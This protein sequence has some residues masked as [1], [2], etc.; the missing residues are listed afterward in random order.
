[1]SS[2]QALSFLSAA[3][4]DYIAE[5]YTKYVAN[6]ASVDESWA[7]LFGELG[8]DAKLLA[9]ELKGASWTPAPEK[10]SAVLSTPANADGA[11]PAKKDAKKAAPAAA[12]ARQAISD[13]VHALMLIRAYRNRGHLLA[14][15]DPLG[16]SEK[17][18][19]PDLD[20]KTYGFNDADMDREIYMDGAFG[21]EQ[22]T[23]REIV[24]VMRDTYCGSIGVEYMHI[25][26]P[27]QREWLQDR[28]ETSLNVT[29]FSGDE[30]KHILERLTASEG[31]EKFLDVKYTGTKRFGLEG[32]EAAIPAIEEII[33][34]GAELGIREVVLGMAHRGR[35]NVLTNV[36]NKSFT[37]MFSEFQGTPAKPDQVQGS[38]DV[39]YH[40]GTS[41]DRDFRGH[42]VHLS[43]TANPSHLEFVDPVVVGKTRAKQSIRKDEDRTEVMA[44]L[45]HGDAALA[46]QGIVPETLM[47]S[48]LGGYRVGGTM[49][50][51]INNQIGFTTAPHF[52]RSGPYCTDVAKMSQSPIFHVNGDDV[53]AVLHVARM[54]IEFRQTFHKDVFVDV[55]CY[56]RHG[57]N[58]GDEPA[59]T[60]PEMYKVIRGKKSTRTLYAEK[61]VGEGALTQE[62]ADKIYEDW[63]AYLEKEFQAATSYKPNRADMLE[64]TWSGLKVAYGEERSGET[65]ITDPLAKKIGKALTTVPEDFDLN[66]KIARQLEAKKEM[67]KSGEGFDWATAEALAFGSLVAEGQPVRLSG[68]DCGRGTFSQR[69]AVLVDQTNEDRY[70]P[71]NNIDAK[72][73]KFGVHD[74]PLSEAAVLGFEYGYSM[75]APRSLVLWEGQFGDFVNGAQVI[76]DQ[77]IASAETKWLRMSGL[78]ML[79]PHGFEGQGPEHSSGRLERFLQLSAEDNW[80]VL[81]CTTPANY[82]HALRRQMHR[83]FRKPLI[84]MTPKSL[85]R[86]KRCVS[87]LSDFIGKTRFSRVIGET[88]KIATGKDVKRVVICSGKVDYDLLD[89]R[90]KHGLKNVAVV[91][92][93]QLYPFP[94]KP[95]ADELK[96]YP[97]AEIIWCQEEPQNQGGWTFVDRRIESVLTGIKHKAGRPVYVGR[98]EAA[99]PATGSHKD[100][101]K[102]QEN[103]VTL[104]LGL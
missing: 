59:F 13:A 50:V 97:N 37:A 31:F 68:Q 7:E 81:N 69:H 33:A 32:G 12:D 8:E 103:I 75:A 5:L 34:R 14:H 21:F 67:F 23:L 93:E 49:H 22:T 56:R 83:D 58:E 9:Q 60:Q 36:M 85:L 65:A 95:L 57:H 42:T 6:P 71:L 4:P 16:L 53:E 77:F 52:S 51:V 104:A 61:L 82:F 94:E 91:R 19:H 47:M 79:L 40:L 24:Q 88:E 45:L 99:A 64:G 87:S 72:Q 101:V 20:P 3:D 28:F 89:A 48:D 35:L 26:D 74:S 80:Q 2:S 98:A 27:A 66:G 86:H 29:E 15:L 25:Q 11:A 55:I 39:K 96:K 73:A 46:G 62:T 70:I 17:T 92:L 84:V 30:K 90:E 1:M 102:E 38:G 100:H 44:I 54:A 41:S 18:Y 76:I 78:V 43:L 10:L 63:N